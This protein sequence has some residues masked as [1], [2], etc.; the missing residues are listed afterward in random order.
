MER[1]LLKCPESRSISNGV[2]FGGKNSC[3]I[4]T[5]LFYVLFPLIP[6]DPY[7]FVARRGLLEHLQIPRV[8]HDKIRISFV[9]LRS[10]Q[11]VIFPEILVLLRF[12]VENFNRL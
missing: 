10:L 11:L 3:L 2:Q 5:Q 6:L 9:G 12:L 7:L 4:P 8:F 1:M